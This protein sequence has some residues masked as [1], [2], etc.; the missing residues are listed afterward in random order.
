MGN[1]IGVAISFVIV[2]VVYRTGELYVSQRWS[3]RVAHFHSMM[4][5]GIASTFFPGLIA[6]C[7]LRLLSLPFSLIL[8]LPFA[9]T[10]IADLRSEGLT[11]SKSSPETASVVTM[12]KKM[13]LR[14]KIAAITG[15]VIGFYLA[16]AIAGQS[17][18]ITQ[19]L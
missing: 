13:A 1:L 14:Q 7:I 17:F 5:L 3:P 2:L 6:F 15:D 19:V 4:L 16:I 9:L 8:L 18:N 11:Y 12:L 10:I